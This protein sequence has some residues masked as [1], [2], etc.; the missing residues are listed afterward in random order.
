M[1]LLRFLILLL[2]MLQL[3]QGCTLLC[4]VNCRTVEHIQ[5]PCPSAPCGVFPRVCPAVKLPGF[6]RP[7]FGC[8]ENLQK[9]T[10]LRQ[11]GIGVIVLGDRLRIILPTDTLFTRDSMEFCAPVDINDCHVS[12]LA[13]I[14][15]I[16]KCISCVPV[17]ITGHTDDVGSRPERFRRSRAMAQAVAAHLWAQGVSWDRLRVIGRADCD[18]I[19]SDM[20]VFGSTDNRR[21]EIRLDF[22]RNYNYNCRYN[23]VYCPDCV[24]K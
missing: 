19:A 9:L 13:D 12:T 5:R 6:Y 1:R 11:R 23:N 14:A 21:V 7:D 16:I 2:S 17:V 24:G 10:A 8:I 3:L 15:E 20:S 18:P 22:S 4:R